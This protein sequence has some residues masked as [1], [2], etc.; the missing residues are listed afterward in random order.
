M[1]SACDMALRW[2]GLETGGGLGCSGVKHPCE[3]CPLSP[4]DFTVSNVPSKKL[5]CTLC[6]P[7][8]HPFLEDGITANINYEANLQCHHHGMHSDLNRTEREA[9][10]K[11]KLSTIVDMKKIGLE[12]NVKYDEDPEYP[13]DNSRNDFES[14][15]FLPGGGSGVGCDT[16][17][18]TTI[19]SSWIFSSWIALCVCCDCNFLFFCNFA[20][21]NAAIWALLLL[22]GAMTKK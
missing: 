12:S 1:T 7:R 4:S 9:E 15:H 3:C 2:N 8:L 20:L 11:K 13:S 22:G 10:L 17:V 18:P 16:C 6:Q 21:A 19:F 5:T 14:L